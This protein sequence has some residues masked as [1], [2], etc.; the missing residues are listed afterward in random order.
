MKN[1][2][3]ITLLLVIGFLTAIQFK[4]NSQCFA[5]ISS[6]TQD[7]TI[8]LG[9]S[10]TLTAWATCSFLMS[11]NFNN[12]TAGSGW[13]ATTG[14][15]FSNPC[16]PSAD[17]T[18]YMWMG[19]AVSIPRTLTTVNF[20]VIGACEI[21]FD[22][23]YA[24]QSVASPCEGIDEMDE[25]VTLQYSINNGATWVDIAYFRP[26]GVI[27]TTA[28][29]PGTNNTSITNYNTPFTVW[30]NYSFPVP[31][32]A[33]S[34]ATKFRWIQQD[35]SSTGNDHWGLDNVEIVCPQ[36]Q[37][38]F[39]SNGPANTLS[40]TVSPPQTTEYIVAIFDSLGNLATDTITV[41][42]VQSPSADFS[43]ISPVCIGQNTTITY[44][45]AVSPNVTYTWDFDGGVVTSGSGAGP[46]QVNWPSTG[47][48]T[49]TLTASEGSCSRSETRDI[50][51]NS[52]IIVNVTPQNP[53]VCSDSSIALSA[54]GG[55][56]YSWAPSSTLN[57]DSTANV[58][59][60]P[61]TQTTYTVTGTSLEGCTGSASVTVGIFPDP[62]IT[63]SPIPAEGCKPVI[64]NF[65]ATINPGVSQ[66]SWLFGDPASGTY[67]T[68]TSAN[69]M[70]VYAIPG[71]YDVTL[72]VLSSDGC[73][74]SLTI[75]AMINVYDIPVAAFMADPTTVN[76][77][78]PTVNFTDLSTGA[79][80]WYWDFGD[81]YS[82]ANNSTLQNPSH[83]YSS[84][85]DYIVWL[86]ASNSFGCSD[87]AYTTINVM[88]DIAFWIPNAFTPMNGD[89]VNDVFKPAG[90]GIALG[91]NTYSMRIFDRWGHQVFSSTDI[92]TGWDGK[93]G[94]TWA[95]PGV[96]N[97]FIEVQYGDGLWHVFSGKVNVIH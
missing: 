80:N 75:P 64:V 87:S 59:A 86:I 91:E 41:N 90:I 79:D 27:L 89:G 69:P 9:D 44:D 25:G 73:P 48:Y 19:S 35:Y 14:V 23:K 1:K 71:S 88:Q 93:V 55:L 95:N 83:N 32:A 53:F 61:S 94:G 85:G 42:V 57:I 67:N 2:V 29:A 34:S 8:C 11:N 15:D 37:N 72:D 18:T 3:W 5:T 82:L 4:A 47:T 62:T 45:S 31:P 84:T 51:V 54:N 68:S 39:W 13:V 36:S 24:T 50:V 63:I 56:S 65:S 38:I 49:I 10:V 46:Y 16:N 52:D 40:Q 43:L 33:Q 74:A 7:T 81:L 20:N 92:E 76:L 70:H 66:Y 96:Y 26:D 60:T 30:G 77:S 58:I 97:Y 6:P 22:M 78:T 12:G 28:I 21:S 17:G